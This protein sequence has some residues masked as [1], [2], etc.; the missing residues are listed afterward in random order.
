MPEAKG[1]YAL[2][3][4]TLEQEVDQLPLQVEGELP[5]W[6]TGR[7]LRTGPAKFEV[8]RQAYTHWFDGLAMLHAFDFSDGAVR[9]SNRFIRSQSYCEAM[10]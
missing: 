1:R 8:G 7:L 3:F 4:T 9:Y 6:L 5:A 2:G 10:E